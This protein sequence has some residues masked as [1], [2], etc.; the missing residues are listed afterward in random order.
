MQA[1][2]AGSWHKVKPMTFPL[3]STVS[4]GLVGLVALA[5]YASLGAQWSEHDW[6]KYQF[7]EVASGTYPKVASGT[8][9][10]VTS[11]TIVSVVHATG[12]VQPCKAVPVGASVSGLL[13]ELY[14][15]FNDE[16]KKGQLLAK[17]DSQIY[18]ANVA[19]DEASL[20][21]KKAEQKRAEAL[22]Q[23]AANDLRRAKALQKENKD[24]ISATEMDQFQFNYLQL[25]AQLEVA[26]K[27]VESA[28][29]SLDT[30][31]AKLNYTKITS[32]VDG[33]IIH[34]KVDQGQTVQ[35]EYGTPELFIVARCMRTEVH[36]VASVKETDISLIR[37]VQRRQQPVNFSVDSYPNDLFEGKVFQIRMHSTTAQNGASYPVIVTA[38]NPELK[39]LP[40]MTARLR[41]QVDEKQNVLRIPHA[42]L[43]FSPPLERVP[44]RYRDLLGSRGGSSEDDDAVKTK[45]SV[46]EK[47]KARDNRDRHVWVEDGGYLMPVKVITGISNDKYAELV[48]G[49]LVEAQPLVTGMP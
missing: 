23:Q 12:T 24:F 20:A 4:L 25:E 9:A 46:T 41:F 13:E 33:I 22:R 6:P 48:S 32:P 47:T 35:G 19:R 42:A 40:G 36:V 3:K 38:A 21:T 1:R 45:L 11:G 7:A 14:V 37:E 43:R 39:L 34:R 28:Q 44:P 29:A 49:D 2:G 8:Y 18:Q 10:K 30:S 31:E 16:V 26:K 15:D 17:I 27:S 5:A